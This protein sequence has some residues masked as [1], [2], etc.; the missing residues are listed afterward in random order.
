MTRKSIFKTSSFLASFDYG[1]R[2]LQ[3]RLG[4]LEE[5]IET[6]DAFL[7][8]SELYAGVPVDLEAE[9]VCA[10]AEGEVLADEGVRGFRGRLPALVV[11]KPAVVDGLVAVGLAHHLEH[12]AGDEEGT[13][14]R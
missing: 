13:H 10:P 5:G 9:E 2:L 11:G 12:G 1:C 3:D 7:V 8:V 14:D 4:G 6:L